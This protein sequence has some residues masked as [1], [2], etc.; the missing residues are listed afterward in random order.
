MVPKE[1]PKPVISPM[2]E[3]ESKVSTW[4][5]HAC[6]V[7]PRRPTSILPHAEHCRGSAG[8]HHLGAVRNS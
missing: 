2:G 1:D 4:L 3:N 8:L 5:P 7:I 6:S